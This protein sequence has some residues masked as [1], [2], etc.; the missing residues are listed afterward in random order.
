MTTFLGF[1]KIFA[2]TSYKAV[3]RFFLRV[4][5]KILNIEEKAAIF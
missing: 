5:W 3:E 1:C 4:F 2:A